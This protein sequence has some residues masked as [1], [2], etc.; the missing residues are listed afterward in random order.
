MKWFLT[1]VFLLIILQLHA[2]TNNFGFSLGVS[3]SRAG[4]T[5]QI[6]I[7]KSFKNHAF[8]IGGQKMINTSFFS[9]NQ[10]QGLYANWKYNLVAEKIVSFIG[11]HTSYLVKNEKIETTDLRPKIME[12]S[13]IQGLQYHFAKHFAI[14]EWLGIGRYA[15]YISHPV[16]SQTKIIDWPDFS[17]KLY[18]M[19][20]F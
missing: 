5:N 17:G 13:I 6:G 12:V 11:I 19:F 15:E 4:V 1:L 2:Q 3:V 7:Q 14:G 16:T 20:T 10:N 9:R 8:S 18:L